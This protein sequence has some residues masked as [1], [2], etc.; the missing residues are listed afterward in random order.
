MKR[1]IFSLRLRHHTTINDIHA[2]EHPFFIL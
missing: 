1:G 2:G